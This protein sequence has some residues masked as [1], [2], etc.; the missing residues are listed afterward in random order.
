M[1]FSHSISKQMNTVQVI[2]E[3]PINFESSVAAMLSVAADPDFDPSFKVIVDLRLMEYIPTTTEL[4][5]I[6]DAVV[7]MR[8]NFKGEITLVVAESTLYLA[9][10]VC[11]MAFAMGFQ[12]TASTSLD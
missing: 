2:A 9:R 7:S 8:H 1:P 4:F 12:M 3:G 5:G 6:R 10:L 11:M